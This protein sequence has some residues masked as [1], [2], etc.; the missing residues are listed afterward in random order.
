MSEP[1]WL[2]AGRHLPD[3]PALLR[4]LQRRRGRRPAGITPKLDHLRPQSRGDLA[5]PDLHLA[6][7]RLR[8][9]RH[10]LLRHRPGVRHPRRPRRAD[11]GGPRA[12][13]PGGPRLGPEPQLQPAPVV[14]RSRSSRDN[15]KRDWYV[16]RDEPN[17]WV[18]VFKAC[19]PAWTFDE[20]TRPVLPAQLH[21]RAA[22]P[23]LGQPRGRARDARHDPLLDGPR[24]RRPP[25][26]RDPRSP[27]TRCCA[28]TP[29]PPRRTTRTGSRSTAACAAS[30]RSST[31]TRTG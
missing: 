18:S 31:N 15:P 26:R 6:D 16:W 4:G 24:R 25:P 29:A 7:G 14:P 28:T 17:D 5:Q 30:A 12:R 21:A 23:Q 13:D 9:R 2:A 1:A 10:R 22:R 11:R 19:G 27:R 8:L 3:L 20:T